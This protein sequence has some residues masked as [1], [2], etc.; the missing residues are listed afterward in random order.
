MIYLLHTI[1]YHY[2]V[3]LRYPA[4]RQITI[5]IYKPEKIDPSLLYFPVIDTSQV[6][7]IFVPKTQKAFG[8]FS[9]MINSKGYFERIIH[10]QTNVRNIQQ[11]STKKIWATTNSDSN[12]TSNRILHP[13]CF[14]SLLNKKLSP[15]PPYIQYISSNKQPS[16]LSLT[17]SHEFYP[18]KRNTVLVLGHESH[19]TKNNI[20]QSIIQE[21]DLTSQQITWQLDLK[22]VWK[23]SDL[24]ISQTN[25][26]YKKYNLQDTWHVNAFSEVYNDTQLL[27]SSKYTSQIVLIHKQTNK[28]LW[29]LGGI[30][31]SFIFKNDPLDGFSCQHDPTLLRDNRI[32]LYDNGNHHPKPQSRVVEYKLDTRT[33][34]ATLVWSFAIQGLFT[35]GTGSVQRLANKNTLVCWG[36]EENSSGKFP[37]ITEITPNKTVVMD[38]YLPPH[39]G[40]YRARKL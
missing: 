2:Y 34:T 6:H 38:I 19:P 27:I 23:A 8:P 33:M 10:T 1:F 40:T 16:R 14:H 5:K 12:Q 21:Q 22:D 7:Q 15:K 36:R 3:L 25:P 32:L 9:L 39:A 4:L 13:F 29:R 31:N 17:D 26:E 28:V 20:T 24:L 35:P 18:T 30:R 11:D 37:K